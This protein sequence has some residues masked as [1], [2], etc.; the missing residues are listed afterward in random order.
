MGFDNVMSYNE[1]AVTQNKV[2]D[3]Y[4]VNMRLY[5][6]KREDQNEMVGY[7]DQKKYKSRKVKCL[8]DFNPKRRIFY[9]FNYFP[10]DEDRVIPAYFYTYE[11]IRVDYFIRTFI[12]EEKS[13]Y[14]DLIYKIIKIIDEGKY[15]VLKRTCFITPVISEDLQQFLKDTTN[16]L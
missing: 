5:L 9:H 13:P 8:I 3:I 7:E 16:D 4:G 12:P 15:R 6:P 14:G 11:D 1:I 10:E 2:I